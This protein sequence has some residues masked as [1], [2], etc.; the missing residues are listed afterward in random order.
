MMKWSWKIARIAGIDVFIHST[1]FLLI[2]W[3]GFSYWVTQNSISAVLNGVVFIL[4]LFLFVLLHEFGHAL[5]ARKYGIATRD[6]TLLPIGGLARL[7][8]MPK[9]PKQEFWVALAGPLVNFVLAILLFGWLLLTNGLGGIVNTT[10]TEGSLIQRLAIVNLT[11]LLFNLIPAFPMDGGRVLRA[12]L[13]MRMEYT[14][15]TQA[16]ATIGQGFALLFGLIGILTNPMLLFIAFFVWIGASQESSSVQVRE[17]ISGIPIR[18]AMLTQFQTLDYNQ[19]LS[20][21]VDAILTGYQQEF[22]VMKGD[23]M[24]GILT[25]SALVQGLAKDG[26]TANIAG[27]MDENFITADANDM[28]ER[29][30]ERLQNCGCHSV[31]VFEN[32]RLVGL[33]TMDNI[34]EFLMIQSAL[35]RS[36]AV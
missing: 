30:S 29:V 34:G 12:F 1:F 23:E 2:I 18:R 6:I 36:S 11:L 16:A 28:L 27:V 15:A 33:V 3:I 19:R 24:V 14:Q 13:A 31:P 17:A 32:D 8:R 21:A 7:E 9:E 22:P 20:D 35:K 4:L 25:R 26:P 10:V 5:A